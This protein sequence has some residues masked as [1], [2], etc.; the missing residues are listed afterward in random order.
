MKLYGMIGNTHAFLFGISAL[1]DEM[2]QLPKHLFIHNS[3]KDFWLGVCMIISTMDAN[4]I[5]SRLMSNHKHIVDAVNAALE[6][7]AD[8]NYRSH[9]R[10]KMYC[11]SGK[12]TLEKANSTVFWPAMRCFQV[13]LEGLGSSYW[14]F[15]SASAQSVLKSILSNPYFHFE[16]KRWARKG[17][18]EDFSSS[19]LESDVESEIESEMSLSDS[20]WVSNSQL[21]Y[22]WSVGPR[23]KKP[24]INTRCKGKRTD[25]DSHESLK[26]SVT[27]KLHNAAFAWMVPFVN[28]LLDFGDIMADTIG[29]VILAL[30]SMLQLSLS[31]QVNFQYFHFTSEAPVN[32]D[33]S[34]V[35]KLA[36]CLLC[37]EALLVLSKTVEHL[38]SNH[39]HILLVKFHRYWLPVTSK[40]I[41]L[42]LQSCSNAVAS[43]PRVQRVGRVVAVNDVPSSLGYIAKVAS[44]ILT[45]P[46]VG[47]QM[48]SIVDTL[49][50]YSPLQ[51]HR[52]LQQPRL[53]LKAK[54]KHPSSTTTY[55]HSG[56]VFPTAQ[57]ISEHLLTILKKLS[58][59]QE[60][61]SPFLLISQEH[62][63]DAADMSILTSAEEA[64]YPRTTDADRVVALANA[65]GLRSS[66]TKSASLDHWLVKQDTKERTSTTYVATGSED[67]ALSD[68]DTDATHDLNLQDEGKRY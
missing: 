4:C 54:G 18:E 50:L 27:G 19:E 28:S 20:E 5:R 1:N 44:R 42:L 2:L 40:S 45:S 64:S 53:T 43:S 61:F 25:L 58:S 49:S 16:L 66:Q 48:S 46:T 57:E 63:E 14:Q 68:A 38:I 32:V 35:S 31:G 59:Y 39:A 7:A 8:N 26:R 52:A 15:S 22:S 6:F 9:M 47:K 67:I 23:S 24:G 30:N 62:S 56:T 12:V 41:S 33:I 3:P 51:T 11:D 37:N 65:A 60:S 17:R 13:L 10:K 34:S 21:V 55:P 29:S 36:N